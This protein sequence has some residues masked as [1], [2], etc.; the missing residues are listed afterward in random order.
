[1]GAIFIPGGPKWSTL[2]RFE[3]KQADK[4]LN[5]ELSRQERKDKKEAWLSPYKKRLDLD[6]FNYRGR[7]I[8]LASP[9]GNESTSPSVNESSSPSVNESSSSMPTIRNLLKCLIPVENSGSKLRFEVPYEKSPIKSVKFT[10]SSDIIEIDGDEMMIIESMR[11]Y[12]KLNLEG[13]LDLELKSLKLDKES[14][15]SPSQS[16]L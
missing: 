3:K 5:K 2:I 9:S 13:R 11:L 8:R 4:L 14:N 15:D 16:E 1:M 6:F 7:L 12:D 10:E